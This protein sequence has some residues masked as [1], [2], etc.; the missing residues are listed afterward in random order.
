MHSS[1]PEPG[2]RAS[3]EIET[4]VLPTSTAFYWFLRDMR[5]RLSSG[6]EA[7]R[8][9]SEGGLLVVEASSR[10]KLRGVGVGHQLM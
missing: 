7:S 2:S 1:V 4:I 3:N 8:K 10:W 9:A 5:G 6:A